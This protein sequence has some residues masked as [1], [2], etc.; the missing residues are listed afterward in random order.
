MNEMGGASTALVLMWTA[1]AAGPVLCG[2]LIHRPVTT[3]TKAS[4]LS[5][6]HQD[7]QADFSL[8]QLSGSA[9][10]THGYELPE[11]PCCHLVF[12]TAD[13]R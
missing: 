13:R 12:P 4:A 5:K 7:A 10:D 1:D 2:N 11:I 8:L 3:W 9:Y 6:S